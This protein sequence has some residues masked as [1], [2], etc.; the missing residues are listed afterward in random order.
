MAPW[1][2]CTAARQASR[3][4]SDRRSSRSSSSSGTAAVEHVLGGA[5][6]VPLASPQQDVFGAVNR[7]EDPS[8]RVVL[9]HVGEQVAIHGCLWRN[10]VGEPACGTA[11]YRVGRHRD[12]RPF[13]R[14]VVG[15]RIE[16]TRLGAQRRPHEQVRRVDPVEVRERIG[17]VRP[18][19]GRVLLA[20]E[21]DQERQHVTLRD[22]LERGLRQ[23]DAAHPRRQIEDACAPHDEVGRQRPHA[24]ENV[25]CGGTG[26]STGQVRADRFGVADPR[27]LPVS[28]PYASPWTAA[29][30]IRPAASGDAISATCRMTRPRSR[31]ASRSGVAAEAADVVVHPAQR[32]DLVENAVLS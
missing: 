5:L 18:L 32:G 31:T 6:L 3:S 13:E 24:G 10:R 19:E 16:R 27:F 8:E 14:L 23:D 17:E 28:A 26:A 9:Q 22:A 20:V 12:V 7:L 1:P 25:A 11:S 29:L 4:R 2:C 15:A 30:V 21:A